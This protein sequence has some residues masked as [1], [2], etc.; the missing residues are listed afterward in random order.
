ML[1]L[2]C[3]IVM[4]F[5]IMILVDTIIDLLWVKIKECKASSEKYLTTGE[6]RKIILGKEKEKEVLEAIGVKCNR[7]VNPTGLVYE[8]NRC[9]TNESSNMY[10]QKHVRR[11]IESLSG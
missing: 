6:I 1:L 3:F 5:I 2:V 10:F 9:D 8:P 4:S 7:I 11:V